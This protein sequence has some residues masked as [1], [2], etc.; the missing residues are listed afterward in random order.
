MPP[1]GAM[2]GGPGLGNR[3]DHASPSRFRGST[4]AA[5]V[6]ISTSEGIAGWG[7]CHA[8]AA[9]RVHKTAISDL[10]GPI[11]IGQDARDVEK[12]WKKMYSTQRT[13]GYSTGFYMES[14][15]GVD[16]ARWDILGKYAGQPLYRLLGGKYGNSAATCTG[17]GGATA[18]ALKE[19]A[20]RAAARTWDPSETCCSRSHWSTSP[21]RRWC[22]NALDQASNST[23]RSWR[24]WS[25]AERSYRR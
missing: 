4:Q 7:E 15:A 25:P 13:R 19:S 17:I 22:P 6:K 9:P 11:L 10:L 24:R 8:P 16:L 2:T 23:R 5:L 14:L 12:L 20:R 3:L 21:A 1:V 18:D